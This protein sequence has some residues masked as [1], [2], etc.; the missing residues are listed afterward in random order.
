[1]TSGTGLVVRINPEGC[2]W[3]PRPEGEGTPSHSKS[4]F[5]AKPG[6]RDPLKTKRDSAPRRPRR[7]SGHANP[8]PKMNTAWPARFQ[9]NA[10]NPLSPLP[11]S[12]L[13]TRLI[14][15][16]F[17]PH[18]PGTCI[19]GPAH[20]AAFR[21]RSGQPFPVLSFRLSH[22]VARSHLTLVHFQS[23]ERSPPCP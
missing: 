4:S 18:L 13:T 15:R 12:F 2:R 11:D 9:H 20:P 16:N 1:M 6:Q 17:G 22:S 21:L 7:L 23:A 5:E 10:G 14:T 8:C 19:P 3:L